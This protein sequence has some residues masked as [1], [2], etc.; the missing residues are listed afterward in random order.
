MVGM[1]A[2]LPNCTC[3]KSRLQVPPPTHTHPHPH[4]THGFVWIIFFPTKIQKCKFSN[5]R[6]T[7]GILTSFFLKIDRFEGAKPHSPLKALDCQTC[8][9][10]ICSW[11][12]GRRGFKLVRSCQTHPLQKWSLNFRL[13]MTRLL[14]R[15]LCQR[16][17]IKFWN[18]PSSR[19]RY[20]TGVKYVMFGQ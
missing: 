19:N 8:I 10:C 9:D 11:S 17:L 5:Q 14:W 7:A 6:G 15:A 16:Y 1:Q 2:R 18:R 12:A 3:L 13:L 20:V 4:P